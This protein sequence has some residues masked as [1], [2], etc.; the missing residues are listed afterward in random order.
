MNEWTVV[1][2]YNFMRIKWDNKSKIFSIEPGT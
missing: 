2:W 1:I